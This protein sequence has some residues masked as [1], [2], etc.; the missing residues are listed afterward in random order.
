MKAMLCKY[1]GCN[2]PMDETIRLDVHETMTF[3]RVFGN[4][5][6]QSDS[7]YLV[8]VCYNHHH[9]YAVFAILAKQCPVIPE[10]VVMPQEATA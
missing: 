2:K 1:E 7:T 9:P 10:F 5:K 8:D 6:S 4:R 3:P